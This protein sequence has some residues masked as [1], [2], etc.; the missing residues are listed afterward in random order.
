MFKRK[1]R[2]TFSEKLPTNLYS[3]SSFVLRFSKN[4]P[5]F[6]VAIVASKKIDKRS[7][8]RNVAKRK[9][10]HALK[11]IIPTDSNFVLIFYVK[12][13]ALTVSS[14]DL[15]KEIERALRYADSI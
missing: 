10:V 8:K 15:R 13:N 1:N 11:E 6:K 14:I 7:T 2:F 5:N 3:S 9:F 12:K 4:D